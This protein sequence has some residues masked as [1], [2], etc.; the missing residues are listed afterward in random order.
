MNLRRVELAA[1]LRQTAVFKM[2]KAELLELQAHIGLGSEWGVVNY[3]K[4]WL[5]PGTSRTRGRIHV[6]DLVGSAE[7]L[8][9]ARWTLAS[10]AVTL[11]FHKVAG[12]GTPR[13]LAPATMVGNL[14]ILRRFLM[15]AMTKP[16][17]MN[18]EILSRL[19][20]T[21]ASQ[22]THAGLGSTMMKRFHEFADRGIWADLPKLTVSDGKIPVV[23]LENDPSE[24]TGGIQPLPD[25]FVAEA[26]W[27]VIWIV[28]KL[29]PALL[30]C[31]LRVIEAR[32]VTSKIGASATAIKNAQQKAVSSLLKGHIWKL[33]DG[34]PLDQLPF[35]VEISRFTGTPTEHVF[36]W[37]PTTFVDITDLLKLAQ[38]AH[39]WVFLLATGGRISEGLSLQRDCVVEV[40][41]GRE[42]AAGRTFKLVFSDQGAAREWPLP[43]LALLAIRQQIQL[44]PML[45]RMCEDYKVRARQP[46]SDCI[47]VAASGGMPTGV[48]NSRL[49]TSM[50]H[51]D[52]IQF[53]NGGVIT[54]HRF[55]KSIARLAALA[56][57]GAPKILMD[58]FG[59]KTIAMTLHYILTDPKL[60]AEIAD[61][62]RAQTIMF[63]QKAIINADQYG[64]PAASKV[65]AAASIERVRLGRDFRQDDV[66]M[67]AETLTDSGKAWALV[68]P[69]VLCTKTVGES[70]PC[71]RSR[72][73]PEPARCRSSCGHR[74]ED[75]VLLHEVDESIGE[76]VGLLERAISEDDE[77]Q[78]EMWRGQILSHIDRFPSLRLKWQANPIVESLLVDSPTLST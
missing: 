23:P 18:G 77:F 71:N 16:S 65:Q 54:T 27:R 52:V 74:L 34:T 43:A 69:G 28:E 58:L 15:L 57:V 6:E 35:D 47:W 44:A 73:T 14:H 46:V 59:H 76:A 45:Q 55:R 40:R 67:L 36:S 20:V 31:A 50:R 61:I 48:I 62:A 26:G 3:P 41:E 10:F 75:P 66:R 53:L 78:A 39:L 22:V 33:P 2:S 29:V 21:E 42:T 68:R 7:D 8:E 25:T 64:G 38:D 11:Y 70:G 49:N 19:T 63:A 24:P 72:G 60:R 4:E 30:D 56:L 32:K 13:F 37:P 5:A 51:L 17:G 12:K 1:S 9:L